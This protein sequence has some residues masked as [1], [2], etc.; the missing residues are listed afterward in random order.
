MRVGHFARLSAAPPRG[1]T[2]CSEDP[3]ACMQDRMQTG[4]R[5]SAA[6]PSL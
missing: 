6:V 5:D 3:A 4:F 1:K 2:N